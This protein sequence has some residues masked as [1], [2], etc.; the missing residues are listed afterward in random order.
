[1]RTKI[2]KLRHELGRERRL[3]LS[4]RACVNM[5]EHKKWRQAKNVGLYMAL[6]DECDP[7]WLIKDAFE[8][9]KQ[10]W[11]PKV[12][13]V[14]NGL[15]N[16]YPVR[17]L[18]ELEPGPMNILEPPV[19]KNIYFELDIMIIPGLAFDR[20]KTRLG[21]GGGFYDRFLNS[22]A[23]AGAR[24]GFCFS[25]QLVERV[26]NLVYDIPMDAICTDKGWL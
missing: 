24:I 23:A 11:L 10:V 13:D 1:M 15:M 25:C 22:G 6:P 5:R 14:Q 19:K 17:S 9:G 4:Q 3:T 20:N 2:K 7:V 8:S 18:D 26:P 12:E 16:F 21:Y